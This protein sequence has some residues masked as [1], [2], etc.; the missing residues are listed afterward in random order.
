[1]SKGVMSLQPVSSPQALMSERWVHVF[2]SMIDG[3][4]AQR[5]GRTAFFV[6]VVLKAYTDMRTG[7]ARIS[8][9]ALAEKT[10]MSTRQVL[11]AIQV[12]VDLGYARKEKRGRCNRYVLR[13]ILPIVDENDQVILKASW[14]YAGFDAAERIGQIKEALRTGDTLNPQLIHIEQVNV[15]INHQPGGAQI[16][17]GTLCDG[18]HQQHLQ[19]ALE[20]LVSQLV[21]HHAA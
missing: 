14:D 17:V 16:N 13:E 4:D 10:G 12:L 9:E 1:M 21:S 8:I 15:Q 19:R 2:R 7:E 11:R 5:M 6:Y 20:R 3:G 18:A